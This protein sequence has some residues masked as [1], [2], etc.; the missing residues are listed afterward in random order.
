MAFPN[1]V[2]QYAAPAEKPCLSIGLYLA[3]CLGRSLQEALAY[4]KTVTCIPSRIT[5]QCGNVLNEIFAQS[6][7]FWT[8]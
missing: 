6:S 5:F 3:M 4:R 7:S 8:S 1:K 2:Y